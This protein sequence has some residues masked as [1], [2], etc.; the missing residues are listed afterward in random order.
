MISSGALASSCSS[1]LVEETWDLWVPYSE[2]WSNKLILILIN[3]SPFE[4]ETVRVRQI[5]TM[6]K[7]KDFHIIIAASQS[8]TSCNMKFIVWLC[9]L[10]L[11]LIQWRNIQKSF[12]VNGFELGSCNTEK[13]NFRSIICSMGQWFWK[14]YSVYRAKTHPGLKK[15][16]RGSWFILC[17]F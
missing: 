8:E 13:K 1:W 3:N 7:T 2:I 16:P 11:R 6:P 17:R 14:P 9:S 15:G 10:Q 4:F 5:T 12:W